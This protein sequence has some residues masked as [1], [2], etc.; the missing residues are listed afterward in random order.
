MKASA[1]E[2]ERPLRDGKKM[3]EKKKIKKMKENERRMKEN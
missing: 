2:S 3:K 1:K